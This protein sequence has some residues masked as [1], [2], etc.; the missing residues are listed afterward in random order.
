MKKLF[1]FLVFTII[2]AILYFL[3]I[4]IDIR[5]VKLGIERTL[6]SIIIIFFRAI[7]ITFWGLGITYNKLWDKNI[8]KRKKSLAIWG[9][10][11]I[12]FFIFINTSLL[13]FTLTNKLYR[14]AK[15]PS[16]G[17]EGRVWQSDKIL[18]FRSVPNATGFETFPLGEDVPIRF[19]KNGFRVPVSYDST[20]EMKRPLFLFLGCSFTF[21]AVCLAEESFPYLVSEET[22]GYSINAGLCGG[23]LTQMLLLSKDLIPLYKPDFVVVQHSPWLTQ[24]AMSM[25][26]PACCLASIPVPYVSRTK[27][28]KDVISPRTFNS[29]TFDVN[30]DK[31]KKT[32]KGI[33]DYT[34]F[35]FEIGIPLYLCNGYYTVIT[36]LKKTFGIIPEPNKDFKDVEQFVY[37]NIY[38]VCKQNNSKMIVLNLGDIKYTEN[39]HKLIFSDSDIIFA[40]ADSLLFRRLKSPDDYN[41]EYKHWYFNGK[42]SVLKDP[43]PNQ[44]AH[45]IIAEAIVNSIPA[46]AGCP[47]KG[48]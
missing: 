36:I 13:V 46:V 1:N 40:E 15:K 33:K 7:I 30:I 11:V 48:R 38:E 35:L 10:I 28:G 37:S 29:K 19:D 44:K 17:W 16:F 3:T 25:R 18:G 45:K 27:N 41:K 6:F 8:L 31:F 5:L 4:L 12:I 26:A 2:V 9:L 14:Y 23:G 42:D 24:R 22:K 34:C 20:T 21:G 47:I 43:H 32:K 39:S